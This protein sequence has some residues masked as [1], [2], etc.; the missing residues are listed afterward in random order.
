LLLDL[1]S[2]R[3]DLTRTGERSVNLT[4]GCW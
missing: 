4:H 2:R 3:L 1:R